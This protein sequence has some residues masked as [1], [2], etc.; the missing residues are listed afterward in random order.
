M[1]KEY[2]KEYLAVTEAM[3]IKPREFKIL[4]RLGAPYYVVKQT[5]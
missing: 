5:S 3:F 1:T 2:Y 4:D